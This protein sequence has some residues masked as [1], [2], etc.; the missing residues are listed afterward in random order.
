MRKKNFTA[1]QDN[2]KN[3]ATQ[4]DPRYYHKY[5]PMGTAFLETGVEVVA[6]LLVRRFFRV[7]VSLIILHPVDEKRRIILQ[8]PVFEVAND[9]SSIRQDKG[10]GSPQV[11]IFELA[12][13]SCAS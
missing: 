9:S 6:W 12:Y 5:P 1:D 2:S 13:K 3:R 10:A 8:L 4:T 11:S 7:F